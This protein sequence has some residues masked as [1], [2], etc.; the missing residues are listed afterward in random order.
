[1]S[2][3]WKSFNQTRSIVT[4]SLSRWF[5][6]NLWVILTESHYPRAAAPSSTSFSYRT[7][8]I[9]ISNCLYFF[10]P[11][12]CPLSLSPFLCRNKSWQSP[13]FLCQMQDR[14]SWM[15]PKRDR[16][17]GSHSLSKASR[18]LHFICLLTPMTSL[19]VAPISSNHSSSGRNDN[20][21]FFNFPS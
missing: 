15:S 20:H 17:W 19:F 12:L 4:H 1:M 3:L 14:D 5:S 13:V 8:Q 16:N 11:L 10:A 2:T 7:L 18:I 21:Q 6:E 9:V